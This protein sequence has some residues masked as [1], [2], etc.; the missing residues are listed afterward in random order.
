VAKVLVVPLIQKTHPAGTR[1]VRPSAVGADIGASKRGT[2]EGGSC[3]KEIA[4]GG[5]VRWRAFVSR[6]ASETQ[7]EVVIRCF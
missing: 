7:S 5:T 6:A 2:P 4:T 3:E 1:P